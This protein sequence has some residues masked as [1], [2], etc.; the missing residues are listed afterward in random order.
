MPYLKIKDLG[1]YYDVQGEGETIILL[2][3]GFGCSKIWKEVAPQLVNEGFR[4]IMYDRRGFGRSEGG[5][6]FLDFYKSNNYRTESIDELKAIK[7]FL[8]I[9]TCHLVGQCEGGVVGIDYSIRYPKEIKTLTVAS[10]QCYSTVPMVELNAIKFIPDFNKLSPDI[11]AKMQEWHGEKAES[12]YNQFAAYGGAYGYDRFDLR[13]MLHLVQC[14]VLIL[15]PDRSAIF[16]V[17]QAIGFYRH[18]KRGELCIFPRCGH[19]TYDQRTKDYVKE[20][21]GFIRRS[22]D[23]VKTDDTTVN[24]TCLA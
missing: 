8:N 12:Y 16:D 7:E 24:M 18:L 15:Y 6:D 3:H 4:V 5:A 10:T 9:E 19:N 22:T 20:V 23:R 21:V 11:K 1:I 2:H 17:E 14:P 13:P